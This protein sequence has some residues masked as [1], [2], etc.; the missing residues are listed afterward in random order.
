MEMHHFPVR[1]NRTLFAGLEGI[2]QADGAVEDQVAGS[3]IAAVGAEV[4]QTHELVGSRSF[5][6]RQGGLD[7]AAGQNF[8]GVLVHIAQ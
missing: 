2:L 4:A 3:A 1:E 5:G 7:L 6:I 8:Q